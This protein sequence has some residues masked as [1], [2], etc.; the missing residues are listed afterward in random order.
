MSIWILA[1][2]TSLE[3]YFQKLQGL[4][5]AASFSSLSWGMAIGLL[6]ES[7]NGDEPGGSND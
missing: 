6:R 2:E 7:I 4:A 3:I 1:G 5:A